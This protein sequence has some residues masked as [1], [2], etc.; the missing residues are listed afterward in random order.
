MLQ[1]RLPMALAETASIFCETLVAETALASLDGDERLAV[2]DVDLI[3]SNQV[4]VDIYSRFLFETEVFRR[5]EQRTLG[6][7]ELDE[8][9]SAAQLEAYGDGLDQTSA[10]ASMWVLAALLQRPLLQL[11]LHLRTALRPRPHSRYQED[12]EHFA[13]YE[14]LLS[15]AGWTPPSSSAAFDLDV[16][17]EAF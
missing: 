15:R 14:T 4:V 7:N 8:M 6:V 10:L 12:P 3:G 13:G 5:R 9:M 16:T 1:R 11:A 17:D 2:L